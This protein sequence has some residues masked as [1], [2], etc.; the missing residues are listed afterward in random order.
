MSHQPLYLWTR[1]IGFGDAPVPHV[2]KNILLVQYWQCSKLNQKS[3]QSCCLESQIINIKLKK[4]FKKVTGPLP[5]LSASGWR[6]GSN[7]EHWYWPLLNSLWP[8][9]T[10]WQHKSEST[11]A[12]VMACCLMAPSHYLNQCWLIIS[13]VRWHSSDSNFTRDNSAFNQ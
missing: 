5:K 7:L 6:T 13:K 3:C 8:S 11:L 1:C 4:S 10:I 9:D 12:Q 2:E